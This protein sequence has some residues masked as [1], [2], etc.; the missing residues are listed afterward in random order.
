MAR[1]ILI[2]LAAVVAFTMLPGLAT[3]WLVARGYMV[4]SNEGALLSAQSTEG[5]SRT[6]APTHANYNGVRRAVLKSGPGGHF[7]AK[8]HINNKVVKAV[9]DTGATM[10]ALTYEDAKRLGLRLDRQDFRFGVQTANGTVR[11]A[12]TRIRSIRIDQVEVKNLD[13]I[14]APKG[15]LGMTLIGMGFLGK[16]KTFR[17]ERGRLVLES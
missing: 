6:A 4:R 2:A 9:I 10:V 15:A 7:F 11:Y 3:D 1:L 12:R 16:L 13:V 8:A 5:T 14:V 17:M